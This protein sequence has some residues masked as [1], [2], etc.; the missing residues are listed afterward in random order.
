MTDAGFRDHF[1]DAPAAYAA[2]RPDYP[3]AL[4]DTLAS[5]APRRGLAWD[6]GTGSGQA[7]AGLAARFDR[8]VATDASAAQLGSARRR[9]RVWYACGRAERAPL[10]DGCADLVACAQALHWFDAPAFFAETRR[11]LSPGGIVAVWGYVWASVTPAVD[12]VMRRFQDVVGPYW[13][14]ER[15]ILDGGYRTVPFPFEELAVPAF[16]IERELTLEAFADYLRTWSAS[17]RYE[18]DCG[19]DPVSAQFAS[20]RGVW[21]DSPRRVRW[22]I[23]LRVGR[24]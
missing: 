1:S 14:P 13:P 15:A 9:E 18:A 21:G 17:K 8:V 4:F 7:A 3:P 12:A 5:L 20:F 6:A 16:H 23:A 22:P 2:F 10:R 11:V 24:A 19:A